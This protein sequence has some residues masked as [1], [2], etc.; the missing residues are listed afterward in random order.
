MEANLSWERSCLERARRGEREAVGELYQQ[1]A[2][3]LYTQVLMP[4]LGNPQAA[5]DALSETFRTFIEHLHRVDAD[6][7]TLFH[8]LARVASNKANDM[9]RVKSRTHRALSNFESLVAP[10]RVEAA[11]APADPSGCRRRPGPCRDGH[12]VAVP[13]RVR[14]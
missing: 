1:F 10:L 5:E 8:W 12:P 14:R 2:R 13:E 6:K 7:Q 9:H 4:R 3:R 11:S